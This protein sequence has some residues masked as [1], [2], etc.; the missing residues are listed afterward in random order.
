MTIRDVRTLPIATGRISVE[1]R[2]Y[3][4]QSHNEIA[5][6]AVRGKCLSTRSL[7]RRKTSHRLLYEFVDIL[8]EII[9][10]FLG[11]GNSL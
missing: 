3:H 11:V 7:F 2:D 4:Q 6:L 8:V 1:N 9:C 5:G 10:K